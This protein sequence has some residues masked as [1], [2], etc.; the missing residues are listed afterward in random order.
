M[1]L[2]AFASNPCAVPM[3]WYGAALNAERTYTGSVLEIGGGS[4]FKMQTGEGWMM[5]TMKSRG[6]RT[7]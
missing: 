7:G 2:A 6:K 4:A 3:K 1:S 5:K